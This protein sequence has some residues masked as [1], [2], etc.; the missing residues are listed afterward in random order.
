LD[1]SGDVLACPSK[2]IGKSTFGCLA[3]LKEKQLEKLA[4]GLFDHTITLPEHPVKGGRR[5]NLKSIYKFKKVLKQKV[6]IH[7]E[8][9]IHFRLSKLMVNNQKPYKDGECKEMKTK[10]NL[11]KMFF[12]II[13]T[14]FNQDFYNKKMRLNP[15]NE[16]PPT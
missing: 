7:N 4:K 12:S 13:N 14:E 8:I 5:P 9:M 6:V 16:A 11:N 3:N 2:P 15:S 10:H 1:K